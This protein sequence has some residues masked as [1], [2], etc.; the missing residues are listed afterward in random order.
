M[1]GIGDGLL[2]MFGLT[3]LG[4]SGLHTLVWL[5]AKIYR[6]VYRELYECEKVAAAYR[7]TRALEHDFVRKAN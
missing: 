6:T 5:L 4:L 3:A 2:V 1:N 7:E